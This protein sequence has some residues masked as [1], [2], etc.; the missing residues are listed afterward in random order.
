MRVNYNKGGLEE[1]EMAQWQD[2]PM[3]AWAEWFKQASDL[4][5][6][7]KFV[8]EGVVCCRSHLA[9]N[10]TESTRELSFGPDC[11]QPL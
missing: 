9:L 1:S 10:L 5:V 11:S 6:R 4:K 2:D 8:K 3:R 7:F